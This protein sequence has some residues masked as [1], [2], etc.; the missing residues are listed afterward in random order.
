MASSTSP[1]PRPTRSARF[2]SASALALASGVAA[3]SA[4]GP[5]QDDVP[6]DPL[7]PTPACDAPG[8]LC[9]VAGT[10]PDET[11]HPFLGFNGDGLAATATWLY[12][13]SALTWMPDG[14]LVIDDFNNM[15]IRVLEPDGRLVTIAGNGVHGWAVE[16]EVATASALENPVDVAIDADGHLVIAEL[17]TGRILRVDEGGRIEIVAG[18]GELGFEGDG[19]PARSAR[20][21]QAAG[22]ATAAD[23]SIY[24]GDTENH[25]VRRVDADGTIDGLAG[26]GVPG[27]VDGSLA[28]LHDPQRV[29]IDAERNRLLVADSGSHT[30]RA[31]DLDTGMVTT[32]AGTGTPGFAGDGG[33]ATEAQLLQPYGVNVG[34]EGSVLVAD[35]GNHRVRRIDA[36]G[37]IS[38]I[39]GTG[40]RGYGGEEVPAADVALA[41]PADVLVAPDGAILVAELFNGLVRRIGATPAP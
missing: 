16:G 23:G 11:G 18:T 34:P 27:R 4:E 31:I 13:P 15:R 37:T 21:S 32:I 36:D 24:V 12:F 29:R 1:T 3:C 20:L 35:F 14:R 2:A 38:T 39:A 25:C 33:P 19:G 22:V 26:D 7:E 40:E 10:T 8:A 30:V 17:H 28:R 6:S 9:T 5:G 41:G